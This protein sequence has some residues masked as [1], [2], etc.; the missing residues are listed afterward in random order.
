MEG[1]GW[2]IDQETLMPVLDDEEKFRA[3][4]AEDPA[5]E[6]LVALWSGRP[7]DAERILLRLI[8]DGGSTRIRALLADAWRDQRRFA[9]AIRAYQELVA[10]AAGSEIEA[11]M[12]Q[13]LGKAYF[14]AGCFE[15]ARCEFTQALELRMRAK[16][17]PGLIVSSRMALERVTSLGSGLGRAPRTQDCDSKQRHPKGQHVE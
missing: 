3:A 10:N 14:A 8:V 4:H 11:V 15:E 12:R 7:I 13:H 2:H 9:K 6:A 1:H 5:L 17:A 16:A